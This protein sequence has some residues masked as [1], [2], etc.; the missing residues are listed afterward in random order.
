MKYKELA[1]QISGLLV[2]L[3]SQQFQF[4]GAETNYALHYKI[5]QSW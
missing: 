4:G 5:S 2:A 1:V 3:R